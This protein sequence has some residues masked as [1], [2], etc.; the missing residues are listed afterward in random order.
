[1]STRGLVLVIPEKADPERDA[2]ATAWEGTGGR[3]LRLGRFWDPP[4]LDLQTV[5]V[6][7]NDTFASSFSRSWGYI[8]THR[9]TT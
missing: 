3:V 8:F 4:E 9:T 5:R 6:Y 2:V 1:M 7:G